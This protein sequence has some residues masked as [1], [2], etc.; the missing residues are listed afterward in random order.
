[1]SSSTK[2]N[3]QS[4]PPT[5]KSEKIEEMNKRQERQNANLPILQPQQPNIPELKKYQETVEGY[6][7]AKS[8]FTFPNSDCY[9]AAIVLGKIVEH[10][11]RTVRIFDDALRG[12]LSGKYDVLGQFIPTLLCFIEKENIKLEI[13]VRQDSD[14]D[15]DIYRLLQ[16]KVLQNTL[17]RQKNKTT[18]EISVK[19]V[20]PSFEQKVNQLFGKDYNF[21]VGDNNAFR[22]EEYVEDV[23]IRKA[24]CSFNNETYTK[25][26]NKI[27]DEEFQGCITVF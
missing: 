20:S 10:A 6:A 8:S 16:E 1:M 21:A 18:K 25:A 23:E 7:L 4:E 12:D 11:N 22:L 9:H 3:K 27:F 14:K 13:V 5:E 17:L 15:S 26:I 19:K 2:S 24:I